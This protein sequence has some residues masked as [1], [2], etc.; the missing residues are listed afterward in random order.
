M[1]TS[2]FNRPLFGEKAI[3]NRTFFAP[4]SSDEEDEYLG[5]TSSEDSFS[6]KKWLSISECDISWVALGLL[7]LVLASASY[8]NSYLAAAFIKSPGDE[9][10][11]FGVLSVGLLTLAITRVGKFLFTRK[12]FECDQQSCNWKPLISAAW[13]SAAGLTLSRIG[14]YFYQIVQKNANQ[15]AVRFVQLLGV[16][17]FGYFVLQGWKTIRLIN[18]FSLYHALYT[19]LSTLASG[20]AVAY[21]LDALIAFVPQSDSEVQ[22]YLPFLLTPIIGFVW[23]MSIGLAKGLQCKRPPCASV[24]SIL[25]LIA[26]VGLRALGQVASNALLQVN[27][28]D[29]SIQSCLYWR[30]IT[31]GLLTILPLLLLATL[32]NSVE[33]CAGGYVVPLVSAFLPILLNLDQFAVLP[34]AMRGAGDTS[35]NSLFYQALGVWLAL[36]LIFVLT[37]R[38]QGCLSGCF[39]AM[40]LGIGNGTFASGL[41][42][43][44]HSFSTLLI[45]LVPFPPALDYIS[46]KNGF[47]LL[48]GSV[49]VLGVG[50]LVSLCL[51]A[52]CHNPRI[53]AVLNITAGLQVLGVGYLLGDAS[54]FASFETQ[55]VFGTLL[56]Y[57]FI[58]AIQFVFCIVGEFNLPIV[59]ASTS[60]GLMSIQFGAALGILGAKKLTLS[61]LPKLLAVLVVPF[62]GQ[63]LVLK[64]RYELR[65]ALL[66]I[67]FGVIAYGM[68]E[69][70]L[71]QVY[72]QE[73]RGF[74][75]SNAVQSW[76][77]IAWLS[78]LALFGLQWRQSNSCSFLNLVP[79]LIIAW[80]N[81]YQASAVLSALLVNPAYNDS[82]DVSPLNLS[83]LLVS[84]PIPITAAVVGYHHNSFA[85]LTSSLALSAFFLPY[86][87]SLVQFIFSKSIPVSSPLYTLYSTATFVAATDSRLLILF[88]LTSIVSLLGILGPVFYASLKVRNCIPKGLMAATLGLASL[89]YG[90]FSSSILASQDAVPFFRLLWL[91]VVPVLPAWAFIFS[92]RQSNP[93]YLCSN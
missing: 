39:D 64:N 88:V 28:I 66:S 69:Q 6:F 93:S 63:I 80:W 4:I 41:L 62:I 59:V 50:L 75:V 38:Q 49:L 33:E 26:P 12:Q 90:V 71:Y 74:D 45:D 42:A 23:L 3:N 24:L 76:N 18:V 83:A 58:P 17:V 43:L 77:I 79:S 20:F 13:F 40:L 15:G 78:V 32:S 30:V 1:K 9:L 34:L 87:D 8:S 92:K 35:G 57:S 84:L 82:V 51:Q 37:L 44:F 56:L 73:S 53:N 89:G 91:V 81:R 61:Y 86:T 47:I 70:L 27:Q 16:P 2:Y 11:T 48:L 55:S 7:G 31:I 21:G 60:S 19:S 14:F 52:C 25:S 67:P 29:A 36:T 22:K 10:L 5:C 72:M 46:P 68:S 65:V 54:Y 85:D